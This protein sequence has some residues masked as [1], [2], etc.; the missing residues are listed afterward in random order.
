MEVS[1]SKLGDGAIL[2]RFLRRRGSPLFQRLHTVVPKSHLAGRP[3]VNTTAFL[4]NARMHSSR[5]AEGERQLPYLP[6][7]DTPYVPS[8]PPSTSD[9]SDAQLASL[10]FV[11]S[12]SAS[13]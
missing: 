9:T 5:F 6:H 13:S 4:D 10:S 7:S 8:A 12:H 3:F 2:M 11:R 1:R